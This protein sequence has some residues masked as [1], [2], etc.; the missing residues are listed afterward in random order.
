[1]LVDRD[2]DG[3]GNSDTLLASDVRLTPPRQQADS[4]SLDSASAG[5]SPS[6]SAHAHRRREKKSISVS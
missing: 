2:T 4:I 1:M 6:G 3:T 5:A